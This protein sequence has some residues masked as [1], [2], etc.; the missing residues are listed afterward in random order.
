M[1]LIKFV[2]SSSV[3][4]LHVLK[5]KRHSFSICFSLNIF[6]V[7]LIVFLDDLWTHYNF[8]LYLKKKNF[9]KWS[10]LRVLPQIKAVRHASFLQKKY[11][12]VTDGVW[13]LSCTPST[14]PMCHLPLHSGHC[15]EFN[16]SVTEFATAWQR[17]AFHAEMGRICRHPQ[18][19]QDILCY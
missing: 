19:S 7:H 18:Y 3:T 15:S 10:V 6:T 5:K 8:K 1:W 2:V 12:R 16:G 4:N 13:V 9:F 14:L 11:G 17:I